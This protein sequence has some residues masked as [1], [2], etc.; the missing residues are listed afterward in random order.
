MRNVSGAN[1]T[2]RAYQ[3][4]YT[5]LWFTVAVDFWNISVQLYERPSILA[6]RF[7]RH[8]TVSAST[9]LATGTHTEL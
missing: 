4:T 1:V 3:Y 6:F 5:T 9:V 7:C 8:A 2:P